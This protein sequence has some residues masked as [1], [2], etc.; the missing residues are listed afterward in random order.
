MFFLYDFITYS[1][2]FVTFYRIVYLCVIYCYGTLIWFVS[3]LL[4][5]NIML[6]TDN[7]LCYVTY[8][9]FIYYLSLCFIINKLIFHIICKVSDNIWDMQII[10][11]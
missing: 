5:T 4:G 9:M 11:C 6:F 2:L 7:A 10:W 3:L 1:I 8:V